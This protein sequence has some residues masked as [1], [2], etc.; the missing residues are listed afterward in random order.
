MLR[1]D[2]AQ[3]RDY[4]V[5][6]S[7]SCLRE[8]RVMV[9][10][11][12]ALGKTIIA[13]MVAC[14][15]LK[16]GKKILFLAPTKP[17][18]LQQAERFK[19]MVD[20]PAEKVAVVTG[21]V[22]PDERAVLY[23]SSS[24]VCGTPQTVSHDVLTRKI[25]LKDY[26]LIVFDEAHRTVGDY[27]YVFLGQQAKNT[28][29][30][31]LG[32]TASPSSKKE[33]ILEIC[34]NLGVRHIELKTEKDSDVAP[35]IKQVSLKWEFV[36][37]QPELFELKKRLQEMLKE[38]LN[39]LKQSNYL[40]SSDVNA[41]SKRDLLMLR[42]RI[43]ADTKVNSR[44][45]SL[46]SILAKAM[47]LTH[48]I[49]LLESQGVQALVSFIESMGTRD[50]KTKAVQALL[51][52][53]RL[54]VI[55]EKAKGLLASGV[56]HPKVKRLKEIVSQ[57]SGKTIIVFAHYRDS[58][59]F[60]VG[61]LNSMQGI[62][63]KAFTGRSAGGMTQKQQAA[64]LDEFRNK[65]FNVLVSTSVAEE[66][67]DVPSVDLVIFFEAVPSEIRLIQRRGRA[68]RAK[69]GDALVLVT[70]NSKD[71]AFLWISRRKE[72]MMKENI[73]QVSREL[74]QA[75]V[76]EGQKTIGEFQ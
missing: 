46:L 44:A 23:S 48:S 7:E 72:R 37:M 40:N 6:A 5:L 18:A 67:I 70:K 76:K 41:I 15:L 34:G 29:A 39:A 11:P 58:V 60:L 65:E 35:F 30:L 9:V 28:G 22:S 47:N 36:E 62:S 50:A 21:E 63:A 66:G 26:G 59:S 55:Q 20:L 57:N 16:E 12:T 51:G 13:I 71:E 42:P 49:D 75:Q 52:D 38:E 10:M 14:H 33:K 69:V 17:L 56:E 74:K 1:K 24:V 53:F 68:G 61:E 2:K 19:E 4:Q 73:S 43:L 8:K 64:V 3:L 27:A 25:D 45:F 54:K 32:L 31:V